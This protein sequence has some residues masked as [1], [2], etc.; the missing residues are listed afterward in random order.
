MFAYQYTFVSQHGKIMW[1]SRHIGE[2][3]KVK[4]DDDV[5]GKTAR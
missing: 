5:E 1:E 3:K 4:N 2:R